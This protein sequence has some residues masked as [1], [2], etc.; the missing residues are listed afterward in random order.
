M[1]LKP[2][3]NFTYSVVSEQDKL[4]AKKTTEYSFERFLSI[5]RYYVFCL[6]FT[7]SVLSNNRFG[8]QAIKAFH[9]TSFSKATV[10][11]RF[12]EKEK[13]RLPISIARFPA[14]KRWHSPP[15]VGLSWDSPP[16]P[17]ESVRAYADVTTKISRI[18]GLPNLPS[19]GAPLADF[20]RGLR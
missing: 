6:K 20:S 12:L 13:R 16:P 8:K 1:Y 4:S 18:D 19:N 17:P 14:K 10:V 11:M 2:F 5:Y 3:K 15:P 7:T 9:N